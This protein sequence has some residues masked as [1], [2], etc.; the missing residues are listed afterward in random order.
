ML[1]VQWLYSQKVIRIVQVVLLTLHKTRRWRPSAILSKE[2]N[3]LSKQHISCM[4]HKD[5]S[6]VEKRHLQK[7]EKNSLVILHE[8]EEKVLK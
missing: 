3:T 5:I 7:E 1:T 2:P 4:S 6:V 8:E